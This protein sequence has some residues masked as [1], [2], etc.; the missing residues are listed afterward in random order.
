[1][2]VPAGIQLAGTADHLTALFPWPFILLITPT[3]ALVHAF[4]GDLDRPGLQTMLPYDS[5]TLLCLDSL[6]ATALMLA[7]S[8]AALA[9][10]AHAVVLP[11]GSVVL[12]I[13]LDL[14]IL[15]CAALEVIPLG[16]SV[17]TILTER[18]PILVWG[19]AA[20]EPTQWA[21]TSAAAWAWRTDIPASALIHRRECAGNKTSSRCR[22]GSS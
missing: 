14:A 10:M 2:I 17:K 13:A 6:P 20:D 5:L 16:A 11:A 4:P 9:F 21:S 15:A 7:G 3:R 19:E 12:V 22:F 1:M 18:I 8:G